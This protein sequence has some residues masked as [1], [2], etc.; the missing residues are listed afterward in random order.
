MKRTSGTDEQKRQAGKKAASY[1]CSGDTVGLGTGSTAA[2]AVRELGKRVTNGLTIQAVPTSYAT[3]DLAQDADIPLCG[4][5]AIEHIDIAIDGA[6]QV[7]ES[8]DALKG[9]GAAHTTEKIVASRASEFIIIVDPSKVVS[10]LSGPVPLAVL[11]S[12]VTYV[13]DV[14]TRLGGQATLREAAHKDGPVVTDQGNHVID[15]SF[16]KISSPDALGADLSTIPGVVEHGLFIDMADG[17]FVGRSDG[18]RQLQ[19]SP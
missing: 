18:V 8:C 6:D 17:V 5:S 11:P 9:G 10:T 3:A 15:V 16:E 2:M 14:V 1:V 13:S 12:A 19:P 4:L 7:T